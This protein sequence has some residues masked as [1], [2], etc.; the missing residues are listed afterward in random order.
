MSFE[1]KSV[2]PVICH[3]LGITEAEIRS[4]SQIGQCRTISDV[5][6]MTA[7]GSGCTSCH[8]RIIA[9]LQEERDSVQIESTS[10]IPDVS[11]AA[12]P[13]PTYGVMDAAGTQPVHQR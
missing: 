8:R 6:V 4:A 9:L 10:A 1:P 5:K 13:E 12:V 7:A 3:C 11:A 2:S